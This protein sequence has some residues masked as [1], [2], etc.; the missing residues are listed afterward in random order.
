MQWFLL[1][2]FVAATMAQLAYCLL[3]CIRL[4]LY[5]QP[6]RRKTRKGVSA[7]ICAR[8]ESGNLKRFLPAVLEQDYPEFEVVVVNDAST[9]ET[10]DVLAEL[11]A[12]YRHLRYTTIPCNEKFSHGKKL[13]LTVGIKSAGYDHLLLTDADCYPASDRWLQHMVSNLKGDKQIV[14]GYGSYEKRKGMLNMLIRYETVTTAIRYLS[15]AIMGKPYMGVGRNLA[16]RKSFFLKHRGFASHYHLV[17]GDDDL[18]VNETATGRNTAVEVGRESRT[19]SL[20]EI[21]FRDWVTQKQRHLT[22]GKQY[23]L[24]TRIM[25]GGEMISRFLLYVSLILVCIYSPWKWYALAAFGLFTVVRLLL[26]KLG[27]RRLNERYL[28]LPSLLFDP[29]MPVMLGLIWFSNIFVTKYQ[30]WR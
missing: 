6:Q 23:R 18:F 29:L 3:V 13:A 4:P 2:V 9:D 16:Y 22:A 20:P 11:S 14:L 12:R 30:P 1:A 5:R 10:E 26:L 19:I 28:L 25:L 15:Y 8:N 7:I 24:A 17:S 27:M 21:S